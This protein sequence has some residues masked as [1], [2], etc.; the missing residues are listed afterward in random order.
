[1]LLVRIRVGFIVKSIAVCFFC[2]HGMIGGGGCFWEKD[3]SPDASVYDGS[4]TAKQCAPCCLKHKQ[5][6]QEAY[7]Q[8][9][10][11]EA[12][13]K[14]SRSG[15]SAPDRKSTRLNSSHRL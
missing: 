14:Q 11:I 10:A 2:V 9:V 6:Y 12:Q 1:M 15:D 5:A 4:T 8:R 13:I 7:N 3:D